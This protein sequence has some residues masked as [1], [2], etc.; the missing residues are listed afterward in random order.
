MIIYRITIIDEDN[1]SEVIECVGTFESKEEIRKW[2][3]K[4]SDKIDEIRSNRRWN[5]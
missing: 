1:F 4:N 2:A 5:K 3:E